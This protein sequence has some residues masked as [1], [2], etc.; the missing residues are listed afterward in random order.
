MQNKELKEKHI[1]VDLPPM[2]L[3][4]IEDA[5]KKGY[6]CDEMQAV[7]YAIFRTFTVVK[8]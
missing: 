4:S 1:T 6:F 3:E 2:V 5:I 7:N 8:P